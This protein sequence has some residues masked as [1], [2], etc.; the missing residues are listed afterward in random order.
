[1]KNVIFIAPPVAGKGTQS[2]KLV[3]LGYEHISTTLE[4]KLKTL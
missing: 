1:M 2:S 4:F 3:D